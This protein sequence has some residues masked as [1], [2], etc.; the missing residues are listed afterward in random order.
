MAFAAA[1]FI[2]ANWSRCIEEWNS[3]ETS[4][5]SIG[6]HPFG[7]NATYE[8]SLYSTPWFILRVQHWQ[9]RARQDALSSRRFLC[10]RVSFCVISDSC[11]GLTV[12]SRESR[13]LF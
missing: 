9:A 11:Q 6:H 13:P 3:S 4:D 10:H 2:A 5:S 12:Q 7:Y 1:D 8:T